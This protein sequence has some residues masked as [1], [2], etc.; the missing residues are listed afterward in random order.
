MAR[1][2]AC[3]SGRKA[4]TDTHASDLQRD[5]S[6][7]RAESG[8]SAIVAKQPIFEGLT[9]AQVKI[10]TACAEIRRL[11]KHEVLFRQGCAH[12]GVF[13]IQSGIIRTYYVAAH[14][15]EVTLAYWRSGTL[16]GTPVVLSEGIHPWSGEAVV[17]SEVWL[18]KRCMLRSVV[19]E[20]PALALRLIEALE[21]K[22][23]CFSRIVQMFG[24]MSVSERIVESLGTLAAVHGTRTPEGILLCSPF[25]H[26]AI[27][28][29]VGASRQWVTMEL[30]NL[31]KQGIVR[32][33]KRSQILVI[34]PESLGTQR[35]GAASS[36]L[37]PAPD[38]WQKHRVRTV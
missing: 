35:Q 1:V 38:K 22:G 25:T 17:S 15:R 6:A 21:V 29:M 5:V 13:I 14:G 32:L 33:S 16:V 10:V 31:E 20:I 4:G 30:H 23:K 24:T 3:D 18:F 27:A 9:L 7:I 37:A 34:A 28:S 26:N 2:Y 8:V 36:H 19:E 11:K 12:S